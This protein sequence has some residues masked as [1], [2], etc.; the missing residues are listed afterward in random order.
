[1]HLGEMLDQKDC[2]TI[3]DYI[4]DAENRRLE[5]CMLHKCVHVQLEKQASYSVHV[6]Y[7]RN[8]LFMPLVMLRVMMIVSAV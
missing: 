5:C 1:M 3:S 8:L 4:S 6:I 7:V 2:E